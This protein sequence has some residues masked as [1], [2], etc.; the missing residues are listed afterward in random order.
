MKKIF[1]TL[2][3]MM[4][5]SIAIAQDLT[6]TV[7]NTAT[8]MNTG[9]IDLNVSG[10]V[11]PFTYSWTGPSGFTSNTEDLTG[12]VYGNYSVLV[13][14][15]YCGTAMITVFV[16]NEVASNIDELNGNPINVFP[17]PANEQVSLTSGK[18]L[19]NAGFKLLNTAGQTII[20][21]TGISGNSLEFDVSDISKGVY[22]IEVTNEGIVS[23]TRF[24]KN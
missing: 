1:Y 3:L 9:S 6:Y 14:D 2:S 13:T 18:T 22:F 16:D 20:E 10:G 12:L 24:V 7:I 4:L 11:A 21:K 17:N 23:R 8:G 5:T 19:D 15:K